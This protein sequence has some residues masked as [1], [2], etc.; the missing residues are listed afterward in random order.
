LWK[1]NT[2]FLQHIPAGNQNI[3]KILKLITLLSYLVYSQNLAKSF[4]G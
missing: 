1:K 2:R 3:F 4:C